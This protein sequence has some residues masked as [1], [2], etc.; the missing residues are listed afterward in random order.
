MTPEE[1]ARLD[2]LASWSDLVILAVNVAVVFGLVG[3]LVQAIRRNQQLAAKIRE[4][5][6]RLRLTPA[7]EGLGPV[8]LW[9]AL[10]DGRT[11]N[12]YVPT[13]NRFSFLS[14]FF[15]LL[16]SPFTSRRKYAIDV[17]VRSAVAAAE[18]A[19]RAA[20]DDAVH[21]VLLMTIERYRYLLMPARMDDVRY[22][23]GM[24]R[25]GSLTLAADV[26]TLVDGVQGLIDLARDVERS[27][28]ELLARKT[29]QPAPK[30][31]PPLVVGDEP[32]V[33]PEA[34]PCPHCNAR[35]PV[36]MP[37]CQMCGKPLATAAV[38]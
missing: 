35:T 23:Q 33:S 22:E 20:F 17:G 8:T 27:A 29:G 36:S 37:R 14:M 24:L 31:A 10:P 2:Q 11:I 16:V 21:H 7:Q 9:G 28:N 3:F 30:P 32:A 19:D 6:Q 34:L 25:T 4:I 1:A 26:E 18:S 38:S 15:Q 5:A 12:V 13:D